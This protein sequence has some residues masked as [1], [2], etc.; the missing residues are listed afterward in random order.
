MSTEFQKH[1]TSCLGRQPVGKSSLNTATK[2]GRFRPSEKHRELYMNTD[3]IFTPSRYPQA[4]FIIREEHQLE[5][6]IDRTRR[7]DA[8]IHL[9]GPPDSGK[10][11]LVKHATANQPLLTVRG[12]EISEKDDVARQ[13]FADL[14]DEEN[15]LRRR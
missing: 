8:P 6:R 12:S 10:T 1:D 2:S 3:N 4:N 15:T 14:I 7:A 13:L 11:S 5:E 9:I